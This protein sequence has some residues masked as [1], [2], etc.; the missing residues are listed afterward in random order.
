V[1]INPL[2]AVAL[3]AR[4]GIVGT[5]V[6]DGFDFDRDVPV[7]DEVA[8]RGK[9]RVLVGD[10]RPVGADDL[11]VT[12]PAR[13]AINKAIELAIQFVSALGRQRT[14]LEQAPGGLGLHRRQFGS[15]SSVVLLLPQGE[16]L[17][18]N[19]PY[20]ERLVL[21][22]QRL[23]VKLAYGGDIVFPDRRYQLDDLE[24]YPF[25]VPIVPSNWSVTLP[26]TKDSG[27]GHRDGLGEKAAGG[28]GVPG[29]QTLRPGPHSPLHIAWRYG[30]AGTVGRVRRAVSTS[31]RRSRGGREE[32]RRTPDRP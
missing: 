6:P 5:I 18:D 20:F 21:Y 25:M 17:D 30:P 10:P 1:F 4:K 31:P 26:N 8:F 27:T 32:S 14:A 7:I 3:L 2:A 24:H 23:Q 16:D 11:V 13:I 22:A 19:R 12:M 9:L 28:P 29:V 15:T